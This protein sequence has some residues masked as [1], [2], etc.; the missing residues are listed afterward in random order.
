MGFS[1]IG[2]FEPIDAT[3]NPSLVLA[4]VSNTEYSFLLGKAVHYAHSRLPDS[5]VEEQTQLALDYLVFN[6]FL[7]LTKPLS[8]SLSVSSSRCAHIEHN[9]WSSIHLC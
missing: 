2:K 4:A 9:S 1:E 5:S 7:I 3:T 8:N 6:Y